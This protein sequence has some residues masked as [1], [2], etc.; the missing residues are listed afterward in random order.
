ML[1]VKMMGEMTV[2]RESWH[3]EYVGTS[4]RAA[5]E[6]KGAEGSRPA[7]GVDSLQ[8]TGM[9]SGSSGKE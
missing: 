7:G 9:G 5:A 2:K 1:K 6:Y 3:Q 8:Q 4:S